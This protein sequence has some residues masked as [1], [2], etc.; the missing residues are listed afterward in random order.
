VLLE[1][2]YK[3]VLITGIGS[4]LGKAF[5]EMLLKEGV[6][7]W[8]TSRN[9]DALE[10]LSGIKVVPLDLCN[11]DSIKALLTFFDNEGVEIDLLINNAG[12]GVFGSFS[13]HSFENWSRQINGMLIGTMALTHEMI[14]KMLQKNVGSV[15]TVS[16]LAAEFP[17]PYM[18]G[19]NVIKAG[20]SAFTES[21][22]IEVKDSRVTVIDFRP[23]DHVTGF[24]ESMSVE[25]NT[26]DVSSI[27][28]TVWSSLCRIM[29]KA[30]EPQK[31]AKDLRKTL[32]TGK[33]GM[34]RSGSFF[35]ARVAPFLTRFG[36]SSM[37]RNGIMKYFGI[38]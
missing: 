34:V 1:K 18:S 15:V 23:G 28:K 36:T 25:A 11:P 29:S 26:T 31:A 7:V 19:Y 12:Y 24:N 10:G 2:R 20:L 4:G 22:M 30:P 38:R 5:G 27:E 17:I 21:L 13:G 32:L 6:R 9:V 16:S 35:Q 14:G 33:S 37:K 3:E 8:G